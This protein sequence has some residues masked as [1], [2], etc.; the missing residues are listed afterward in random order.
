MLAFGGWEYRGAT[1]DQD[2][3]LRGLRRRGAW[4]SRHFSCLGF[5]F[6]LENNAGTGRVMST[7]RCAQNKRG[8]VDVAAELRSEVTWGGEEY[9]EAPCNPRQFPP[10]RFMP[11]V[12]ILFYM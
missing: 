1:G 11:R 12:I 8:V 10:K 3:F 9:Q 7:P 5:R 4:V 2:W 6:P